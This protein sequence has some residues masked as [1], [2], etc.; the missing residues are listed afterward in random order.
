MQGYVDRQPVGGNF[1]DLPRVSRESTIGIS[2]VE[3]REGTTAR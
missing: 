3:G 1:G 2:R